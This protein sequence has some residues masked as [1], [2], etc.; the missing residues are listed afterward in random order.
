MRRDM[1]NDGLLNRRDFE[2]FLRRMR[3]KYRVRGPTDGDTDHVVVLVM[4]HA[5][6]IDI[7]ELVDLAGHDYLKRLMARV[8]AEWFSDRAHAYWQRYLLLRPRLRPE[9]LLHT[10]QGARP[11]M[12]LS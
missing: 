5:T 7:H 11:Q 6:S 4:T 8:P 3:R 1:H 2:P 10:L 12:N 9:R